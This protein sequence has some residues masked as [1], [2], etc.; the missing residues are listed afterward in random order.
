M[1]TRLFARNVTAASA[2][3]PTAGT[4]SV[5]LPT[6]T[7]NTLTFANNTLSTV[8][9]T[10]QT[11]SA[12]TSLAQTA[13]Q[14]GNWV[15]RFVSLPLDAQTISANTWTIFWGDQ[16]SNAAA[17]AFLA[18]SIYVWR[19]STNTRVGFVYDSAANIGAEFST[20]AEAQ[21]AT[22]SGSAV[23]ADRGDVLIVE[24]WY[25][26]TQSM[27]TAYTIT[28]SYDGT[29]ETTTGTGNASVATYIETPQNLSLLTPKSSV[30]F[31]M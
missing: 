9:G 17:N 10:A 19:P 26:A 23:T 13:A 14:S 29:N 30:I 5:A 11:A 15:P 3:S 20:T 8:K 1:A 18:L 2:V 22:I 31:I 7:A 12:I 16:E 6:G 28:F 21:S 24:F 25:T 4:K 27:G